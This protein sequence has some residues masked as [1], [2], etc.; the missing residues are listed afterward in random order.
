[1][2]M[3]F[4]ANLKAWKE[5]KG[6]MLDKAGRVMRAAW[7][8][9]LQSGCMSVSG[10]IRL[11]TAFA[12]PILE[13]G[14]EIWE[15]ENDNLWKEAEQ[16]QKEMGTKIL[17]CSKK[18]AHEFVRGE[19]GWW[20]LR[21]R[22]MMLRLRFWG[23]LVRMDEGRLV[24]KIYRES[25]RDHDGDARV[26]NWCSHT[27]E[28]LLLLGLQDHWDN[29][30]TVRDAGEWK[31][32][33]RDKVAEWENKKWRTRV[34]DNKVL[35]TYAR[36]K[37]NLAR[38]SYLDGHEDPTGRMW[39]TRLRSGRHGLAVNTGRFNDV[40]REERLCEW[41]E[42]NN[43]AR[44]I[45]DEEHVMLS[46]PRYASERLEM[47]AELGLDDGAPLDD[48]NRLLGT[49]VA[50]ET[51]EQRAARHKEVKRF[52]RRVLRRRAKRGRDA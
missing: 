48:L 37:Q 12:R 49:G 26:R 38:E 8:M 5:F 23:K 46:C 51:E 7:G 42:K 29:T 21:G 39:V 25:K 18:A 34:E 15:R 40:P 35:S 32:L 2:G 44:V 31:E 16:L 33:V 41:C 50:G 24:K 6:R 9:G 30:E 20:T 4:N 19:L 10:G 52:A 43:E 22:R 36:L 1:L 14:A 45:E 17:R 11:W 28:L 13:Y 3:E 27:H 47:L